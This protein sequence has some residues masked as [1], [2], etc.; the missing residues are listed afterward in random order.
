[1]GLFSIGCLL[2]N[3]QDRTRSVRVR[4]VMVDTGSELTWINQKHLEKVGIEPEKKDIRFVMAN[5][6]EITRSIGFAIIHVGKEF[7]TDEVVFAQKVDLQLLGARTLDGLNLKVD[8]RNRTLVAAGPVVAA[9]NVKAAGLP[10]F[11]QLGVDIAKLNS[12]AKRA[13]RKKPPL[14]SCATPT[15]SAMTSP[16]PSD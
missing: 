1:M 9:D 2:E 4:K 12:F 6:Q 8:S 13:A 11:G 7:T 10:A 3:Q 14:A 16:T 5:R 15:L